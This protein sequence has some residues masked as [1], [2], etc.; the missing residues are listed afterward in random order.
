[1]R[2]G[3]RH[4]GQ[5]RGRA[6]PARAVCAVEKLYTL[7]GVVFDPL[8]RLGTERPV[9][10][11]AF[12]LAVCRSTR[13]EEWAKE[14]LR[15]PGTEEAQRQMSAIGLSGESEIYPA[16]AELTEAEQRNLEAQKA[17]FNQATPEWYHLEFNQYAD[18]LIEKYFADEIT[19]DEMVNGLRQKL[20]MVLWG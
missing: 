10:A 20:R 5:R 12:A 1:M 15:C 6:D 4:T 11:D 16:C 18:D 19:L 14:L 2:A 17:Y 8:P 13:H 9:P 3:G 7:S